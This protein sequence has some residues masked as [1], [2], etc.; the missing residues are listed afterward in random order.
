[1][2]NKKG[3]TY[4]LTKFLE[5]FSNWRILLVLLVL[6][7][8]FPAVVFPLFQGDPANVPLDLQFSYSPTKAYELLA[9]FS[10]AD[11]KLYRIL[12]LTGDIAY[13]I[14][15]GVFLS[16]LIFKLSRNTIFSSIPLLA[17]VADI[18][19]N[20]GIVILISSLPKE[21]HTLASITSIFSSLKWILIVCS[22]LLI[23]V[24]FLR[25]VFTSKKKL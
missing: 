18:L 13:P 3:F 20:S 21:L 12:E 8:V 9:Q 23:I 17:I 25:N 6:N 14:I 1:M 16:L 10:A 15:Y 2:E 4:S 24:L 11:L 22:M 19:E 5:K 7:I